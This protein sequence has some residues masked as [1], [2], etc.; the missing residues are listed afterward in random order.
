M[1]LSLVV[2]LAHPASLALQVVDEN[3]AALADVA[4]ALEPGGA[5]RPDPRYRYPLDPPQGAEQGIG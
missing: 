3:G 1:C 2:P 4:V 5:P